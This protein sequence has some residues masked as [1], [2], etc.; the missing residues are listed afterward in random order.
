MRRRRRS[1][2][3]RIRG[4]AGRRKALEIERTDAVE[5]AELKR[6][7]AIERQRIDVDLALEVRAHHLV[8]EARSAQHRPEE[9]DRDRRRGARHRARRQALRTDRC[10]PAGQAGRD[11]RPQGGRDHGRLARAG[12]GS[13]AARA[14]PRAIEQLEV[15]RVQ[16]LR[17]SRDRLPRGGRARPHRLRSRPGRGPRRP[18]ARAAQ[19]RGQP[20][21]GG[22]DAS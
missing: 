12:A 4:R 2:A 22:R 16:S 15:A 21:E 18:R 13:R 14:P 8:Q 17:G 19:A 10:R 20:R 11:R 7:D 6:R 9:G 3:Q 5:A 1:R